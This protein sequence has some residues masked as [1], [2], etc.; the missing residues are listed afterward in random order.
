MLGFLVFVVP[1]PPSPLSAIL[2]QPPASRP[3]MFLPFFPILHYN[4]EPPYL[5]ED[6]PYVTL[7][8]MYLAEP[9]R[10]R[11]RRPGAAWGSLRVL[12]GFRSPE[13]SVESHSGV[14]GFS[15][16]PCGVPGSRGSLGLP[17][18]GGGRPG[19]L[20]V[21]FCKALYLW[22]CPPPLQLFCGYGLE[23]FYIYV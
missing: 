6:P 20:S 16:C 22:R 23:T 15:G 21:L 5:F 17:Q 12:E 3:S 19:K 11:G 4:N 7:R 18:K 14:L 13:A 2:S 10:P 1:I 9:S 8:H